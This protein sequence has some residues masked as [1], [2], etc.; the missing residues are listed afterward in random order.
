MKPTHVW[1][2]SALGL[3]ALAMVAN[4]AG[5]AG[6]STR[7]SARLQSTQRQWCANRWNQMRM[8]WPRT[9]ALVSSK[10]VCAVALAYTYQAHGSDCR[11][12]AY[13]LQESPK[14]CLD[15]TAS[16]QCRI[17]QYGAYGCTTHAL[18]SPRRRWNARVT[19]SRELVLNSPPQTNP[20]TPVPPWATR[21][22]YRDGFILPWTKRA[23]LRSGL[24]LHGHHA[25]TCSATSERTRQIGALRCSDSSVHAL[26]DPCFPQ[27]S[28]W[29]HGGVVAACAVAPGGVAFRRFVIR[30]KGGSG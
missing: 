4:A 30:G 14:I 23:Q 19:K 29:Q 27:R 25:G 12:P 9:I 3:L 20:R 24:S 5:S 15:P 17:N 28:R 8:T 21:Y 18:P 6:S 13:V 1:A 22:P 7:G 26:Y 16:F 2:T 11:S 10:P